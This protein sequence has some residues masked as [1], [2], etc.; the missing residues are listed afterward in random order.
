MS[1]V[2]KTKSKK[3]KKFIFN[4]CG[5]IMNPNIP[6]KAQHP[7]SLGWDY[8]EISTGI[9]TNGL[10]AYGLSYP[11]GASPC[12]RGEYKTEPEAI[13]AAIQM[14]NKHYEKDCNVTSEKSFQYTKAALE[15]F[16]ASFLAQNPQLDYMPPAG[17]QLALF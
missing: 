15:K 6:L 9:D 13:L 2:S 11:C 10:W 16:S 8:L 3:I 4:D 12:S 7:K 17:T 5:V 14:L 1:T